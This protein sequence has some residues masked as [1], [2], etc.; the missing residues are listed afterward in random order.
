MGWGHKSP[1]PGLCCPVTAA[2]PRPGA[3]QRARGAFIAA[4]P[5]QLPQTCLE[6]S[7]PLEAAF[8]KQHPQ[9]SPQG[10]GAAPHSRSSPA[11]G[12]QVLLCHQTWLW[13]R[14]C[15]LF[16]RHSPVS[17]CAAGAVPKFPDPAGAPALEAG[18]ECRD[19]CD[20]QPR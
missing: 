20:L 12:Q 9:G 5:A 14:W 17:R 2:L 10:W 13:L 19:R 18:S 4:D 8:C 1:S 16:V 3:A 11:V 15:H 7:L 6:Q